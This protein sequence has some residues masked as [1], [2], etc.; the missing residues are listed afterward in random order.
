MNRATY[1]G[2]HMQA[3]NLRILHG[4]ISVAEA[5]ALGLTLFPIIGWNAGFIA[6]TWL[7]WRLARQPSDR[8][9]AVRVEQKFP[10]LTR[11]IVP[12]VELTTSPDPPSVRGSCELIE[13]HAR[14]VEEHM[15]SV[16]LVSLVSAK[17]LLAML[18]AALLVNLATRDGL[19]NH[20]EPVST[21]STAPSANHATSAPL[22]A[23][24]PEHRI[25]QLSDIEGEL[26][27]LPQEILRRLP[28]HSRSLSGALQDAREALQ[29]RANQ[30]WREAELHEANVTES[31][32][33]L[34]RVAGTIPELQNVARQATSLAHAYASAAASVAS[35]GTS[36]ISTPGTG[37]TNLSDPDTSPRGVLPPLSRNENR[38]VVD[39][40]KIRD[41]AV[42]GLGL[43]S[44]DYAQQIVD[45]YA[46]LA[47]Q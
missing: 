27:A 29:D 2:W 25:D 11:K 6:L 46:D 28:A 18:A 30:D 37:R 14:D 15:R 32:S 10:H 34:S 38:W 41:T 4:L 44:Q 20:Q 35:H 39:T 23:S 43:Y 16:R 33:E 8:Q 5:L 42:L 1:A 47:T 40:E 22:I 26:R 24:N 21:K 9:L 45:H 13:A 36:A 12:L 19:R 17:P 7:G 3:R 31:L